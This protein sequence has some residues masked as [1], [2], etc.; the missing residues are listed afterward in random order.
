VCLRKTS[1]CKLSYNSKT[2]FQKL[3]T[4]NP[5]FIVSTVYLA[6]SLYLNNAQISL[7]SDICQVNFQI[8]NRENSN[9]PAFDS[10]RVMSSSLIFFYFNF[11]IYWYVLRIQYDLTVQIRYVKVK[12]F[13]HV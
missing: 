12:S 7:S 11:A 13:E 6:I 10:A 3:L 1:I 2:R 5:E 4:S 8:R 9:E